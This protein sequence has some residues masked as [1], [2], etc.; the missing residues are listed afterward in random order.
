MKN[1]TTN[2]L[3]ARALCLMLVL[4]VCAPA[5]G[6]QT[7][8]VTRVAFGSC[9]DQDRPQPIWD[10]V[11]RARPDLFLFIGDN[12]YADTEDMSVMRAKYAQLAAVAGFRRL[13][14]QVPLLATWDDHDYGANDAG[15]EYP[16]RAESQRVFLDFFGVPADSPL[17]KREGIYDAKVFGPPG[18]RVQVIMLDTRYFRSPLKR[19]GGDEETH[20]RY[21]PDPDPS[22]TMLGPAQ[23]AWLEE[24]L[25]VPAEVR[26]LVSSIQVVA[27]DHGWEKWANFPRER[28][29]LFELIRRTRAAG[30]IILSGDRHLAELS[31]MDGGVGYPLYDLTSSALNRSSWNWRPYETNRHRVGTMNWGDNFGLVAVEWATKDPLI[32]LQI[33]DADGDINIQRK[34]RLSTL[35]PGAIR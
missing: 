14:R 22:K 32:R 18:R 33:V 29:R 24:Q 30:V 13:R 12:V 31:M 34:L 1:R 35:R 25:R 9:A 17:R 26:L 11:L 6:G 15:A 21:A 28:E 20:G 3:V 4:V 2:G 10:S 7:R 5:A 8:A 19:A 16:K 27:E 23:W